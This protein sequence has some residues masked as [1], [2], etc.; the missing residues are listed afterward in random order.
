VREKFCGYWISFNFGKTF[1]GLASSVLKVLKKAIAQKE[2]FD[3]SSKICEN[4]ETFLPL[5]FCHLQYFKMPSFH[6]AYM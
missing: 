3:I 6:R 4:R 5:D 1:T 2:N